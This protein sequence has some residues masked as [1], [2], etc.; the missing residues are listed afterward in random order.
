M[1]FSLV[2]VDGGYSAVA[3]CRLFFAVA[4]LVAEH[5]LQDVEASADAAPRL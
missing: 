2:V 3:R 1:S 5:R 4:S